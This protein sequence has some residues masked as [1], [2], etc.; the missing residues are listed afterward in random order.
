MVNFGHQIVVFCHVFVGALLN[1]AFF[2][3]F[4][5]FFVFSEAVRTWSLFVQRWTGN[6]R[7]NSTGVCGI[8]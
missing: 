3:I 5:A 4:H 7:Q 8:V 6:D 2:V 1:V